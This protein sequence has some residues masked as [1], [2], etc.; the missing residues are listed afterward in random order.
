[1]YMQHNTA[2]AA[3]GRDRSSAPP[4]LHAVAAGP[5]SQG[6][7]LQFPEFRE[8]TVF[9]RAGVPLATS[10]I[11]SDRLTMPEP[12]RQK[13]DRPFIAPLKVD[14]DLLPTTTIAVRLRSPQQESGWIVGEIALEEL[15]TMVDRIRVGSKRLR[16]DR[17]RRRPADRAR[18]SRREAPHRRRRPE[19]SAEDELQFA[20]EFRSGKT[21]V[22]RTTTTQRPEDDGRRR[23]DHERACRSG[24][25]SSNSPR[26]EALAHG[27]QHRNASSLSAIF[28]ALL[29]TVVVRLLLGPVVHPAHLRAD[30]GHPLDCGRQ[31]RRRASRS[32]ARTRSA[33]SATPS[34]RWPIAWSSCRKTSASRNAR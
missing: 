34:T 9:D 18:Q 29:F 28:L 25:S 24:R 11:G 14:D 22:T 15:W 4:A 3:V 16:A 7:V 5:H 10:A 26:L 30:Q 21:R 12:A 17:Q 23:G 6:L 20:A 19:P 8:I 2:R 27:A 13:P 32:A 1:M 33:S 31:A